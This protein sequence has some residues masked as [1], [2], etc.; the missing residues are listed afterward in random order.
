MFGKSI[1]N[2]PRCL[3]VFATIGHYESNFPYRKITKIHD[4]M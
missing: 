3:S 2:I 4:A 1:S